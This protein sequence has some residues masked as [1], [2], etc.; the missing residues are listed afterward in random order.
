MVKQDM[1]DKIMRYIDIKVYT[2]TEWS[3]SH[4][5]ENK[6]QVALSIQ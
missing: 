4:R 5:I 1:T 6:H 2:D 3:Q